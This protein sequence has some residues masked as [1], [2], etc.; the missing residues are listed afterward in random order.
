M[1]GGLSAGKRR[2]LLVA[3]NRAD[4]P[5]WVEKFGKFPACGFQAPVAGRLLG[6]TCPIRTEQSIRRRRT[7]CTLSTKKPEGPK[8]RNTTARASLALLIAASSF[9]PGPFQ[10]PGSPRAAIEALIAQA[11]HCPRIWGTQIRPRPRL[12]PIFRGSWRSRSACYQRSRK[13]RLLDSVRQ[14]EAETWAVCFTTMMRPMRCSMS[15]GFHG[16]SLMRIGHAVAV[17]TFRAR[18]PQIID[19][20]PSACLKRLSAQL[21]TRGCPWEGRRRP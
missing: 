4:G 13:I 21:S 9:D 16:R 6:R 17:Q 3:E 14:D 19:A 10:L 18:P 8:S 7:V 20:R 12:N 1:K 15:I 5:G 11:F 2:S